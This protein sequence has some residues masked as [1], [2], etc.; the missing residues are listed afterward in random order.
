MLQ[1]ILLSAGLSLGQTGNPLPVPPAPT[2]SVHHRPGPGKR[3]GTTPGGDPGE[4]H[5]LVHGSAR[6]GPPRH[7][8]DVCRQER[9]EAP[10]V[11]A[12]L[13]F[14][15]PGAPVAPAAAAAAAAAAATAPDRWLLMKSLQGTWPGAALDGN[16]TSIYGWVEASSTASSVGHN[17]LPESFNYRANEPMLQ[18]A[19]FRIDR[20]VV[21][22]GTTEPTFGFRRLD[23]RQRLPLHPAARHLQRAAHRPPRTAEIYGVDPSSS[24]GRPTSPPSAAAWTSRWA[25]ST[26]PTAWKASRPSA[27]RC[28]RTPTCSATARPSPTPASWAPSP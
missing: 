4:G 1:A 5:F 28:C 21:T 13:E 2:P 3:T 10:A 17:D 8:R 9:P 6:N 12:P 22:S 25:A 26:P 7:A 20:S 15:V 23:R 27:R 11:S 18:Q 24:T 14:S 19:W 16:R